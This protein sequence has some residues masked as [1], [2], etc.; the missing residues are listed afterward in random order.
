M[1]DLQRVAA[2]CFAAG[3]VRDQLFERLFQF[4]GILHLHGGV[5]LEESVRNR[6]EVLHVRSKYNRLAKRSRLDGIL[7]ASAAQT[8]AHKNQRGMLVKKAQLTRGVD[9]QAL[10][11]PGLEL[12]RRGNLA[13]IDKLHTAGLQLL[14]NLLPS[15]EM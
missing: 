5:P 14:A 1:D 15:F 8:F 2:Q 9:Q 10:N 12:G 7:P 4:R 3:L 13:A 6:R 11:V